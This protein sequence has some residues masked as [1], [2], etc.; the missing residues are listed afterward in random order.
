VAAVVER[1]PPEGVIHPPVGQVGA[2]VAGS[3]LEVVAE[4]QCPGEDDSSS[5]LHPLLRVPGEPDS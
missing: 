1:C 5:Y 3:G 4:A 2:W